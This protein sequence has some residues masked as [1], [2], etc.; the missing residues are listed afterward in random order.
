M[1]CANRFLLFLPIMTFDE[2]EGGGENRNSPIRNN[3]VTKTI[4]CTPTTLCTLQSILQT[5]E[6]LSICAMTLISVGKRGLIE[7]V[8]K[9]WFCFSFQ[10]PKRPTLIR[11]L[12]LW[13]QWRVDAQICLATSRRNH[14]R[15]VSIWC[16]GTGKTLGLR[17]TGK[18]FLQNC[19]LF[20]QIAAFS[21][22]SLQCL[23]TTCQ[24]IDAGLSV[25]A[26]FPIPDP[27]SRNNFLNA[28]QS[29]EGLFD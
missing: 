9:L 12:Q 11:A 21:A 29:K 15:I 23:S 13:S 7:S 19:P 1:L 22:K 5:T 28:R 18:I 2:R 6:L 3:G 20:G 10:N 27:K 24:S 25:P 8:N 16:S 17:Y 4:T 26:S 14:W